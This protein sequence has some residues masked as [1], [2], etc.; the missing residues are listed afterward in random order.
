MSDEKSKPKPRMA[1]TRDLKRPT[2]YV[3]MMN[4]EFSE[5]AY[6]EERAPLFKGKWREAALKAETHVPVDLEI[7]TGNG[8]HFAHL[9]QKHP[10][11]YLVGIELKFKPLIQSIRRALRGGAVNARIARYDA[12]RV[13]DLFA[14]GELNNIYIHHPDPWLK[15]RQWKH[16]LIQDE[17]LVTLHRLMRPGSFIDFKTD[18]RDY[19]DWAI[20][21]FHKS[22][23]EVTRETID[24][25]NSEWKDENFVTHFESI[26]LAQG[27]PI[28]YA[29][30]VKN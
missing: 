3:T 10:N 15:K 6:N 26:F 18:S 11:R 16:R 23:F 19:Y 13:D 8:Y 29:R 12:A 1:L 27:Q 30:L 5:W 7:G 14:D 24:L 22:P 28:H 20:E 2:E 4:G 9:A 17:F 25:H 21:R